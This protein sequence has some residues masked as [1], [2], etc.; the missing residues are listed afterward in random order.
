MY[1]L[2][3]ILISINTSLKFVLRVK[4]TIRRSYDRSRSRNICSWNYCIASESKKVSAAVLTKRL[5]YFKVVWTFPYP[6]Y[7][8]RDLTRPNDET[9]YQILKWPLGNKLI[10]IWNNQCQSGFLLFIFFP[11]ETSHWLCLWKGFRSFFLFNAAH[12]ATIWSRTPEMEEWLFRKSYRNSSMI[13][14]TLGTSA[15]RV[16]RCTHDTYSYTPNCCID[17]ELSWLAYIWKWCTLCTFL[18]IVRFV[19]IIS[20]KGHKIPPFSRQYYHC[21]CP[22]DARSQGISSND[23][24]LV[25]PEWSGPTS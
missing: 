23:I 3:D 17:W 16:S 9:F 1:C 12:K 4:S 11:N 6:I 19:K 13:N 21:W 2:K 24:A 15:S 18:N 22:S 10:S 5:P 20:T 25:C 14:L 8:L 7:R